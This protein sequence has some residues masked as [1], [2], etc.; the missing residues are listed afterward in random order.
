MSIDRWMDK[1][2]VV[3]VH[4]GILLSHKKEFNTICS[5]MDEPRNYH[6]KWSKSEKTNIWYH[7]YVESKKND[8]NELIYRTEIENKLMVTKEEGGER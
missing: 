1:E 2:D 5:N 4:S 3:H 8:T 7:L 6:T